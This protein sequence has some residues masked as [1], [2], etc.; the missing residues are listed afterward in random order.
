M[1]VWFGTYKVNLKHMYL[2][3]FVASKALEAGVP[4]INEVHYRPPA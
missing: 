1:S 4:L 3:L 2:M